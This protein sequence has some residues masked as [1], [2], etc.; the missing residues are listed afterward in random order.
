MNPFKNK[1]EDTSIS[2]EQLPAYVAELEKQIVSLQEEVQ[3]IQKG[4]QE[5][6]AKVKIVRYNPFREIGGDQS[7]SIALLDQNDTGVVITS[8]YGREI[9][10]VYGKPIVK[11]KSEYSLS[12]EEQKVLEEAMSKK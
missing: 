8:H 1:K 12:E 4:M 7:F 9:N 6:I 2:S 5:M 3:E 10:R 11:G